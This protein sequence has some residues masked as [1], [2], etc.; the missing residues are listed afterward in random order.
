MKEQTLSEIINDLQAE[1]ERAFK[2]EA[3][4]LIENMT[5]LRAKIQEL[6]TKFN[7][8]KEKLNKLELK[9]P[10]LSFLK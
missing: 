4:I 1:N 5:N 3:R 7:E 6:E 8:A 9:Q 10:D 2:N